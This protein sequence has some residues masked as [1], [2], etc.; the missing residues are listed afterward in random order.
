MATPT[1]NHLLFTLNFQSMTMVVDSLEQMLVNLATLWDS[2][3]C[4]E[5]HDTKMTHLGSDSAT[6]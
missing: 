4:A 5:H 1:L 3:L 6:K 2:P